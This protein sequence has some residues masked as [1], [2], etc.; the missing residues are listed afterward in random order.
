MKHTTGDRYLSEW[1]KQEIMKALSTEGLLEDPDKEKALNDL[2]LDTLRKVTLKC[3]AWHNKSAY[4]NPTDTYFIDTRY[5]KK[6]TTLQINRWK[7]KAAQEAN[8]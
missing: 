4:Y 7:D 3:T 8:H 1:T 6:A 5:V 2:D